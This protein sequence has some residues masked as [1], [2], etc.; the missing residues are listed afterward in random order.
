MPADDCL[1]LHNYQTFI[2][3]GEAAKADCPKETIRRPE[4][5]SPNG[6]LKYGQLMAEHEI[7]SEEG[8]VRP[9]GGEGKINEEKNQLHSLPRNWESDGVQ[10]LERF[11]PQRP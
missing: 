1:R 3:V 4:F 8:L 9:E 11:R 2:P 6:T 7:F 5:R 10:T